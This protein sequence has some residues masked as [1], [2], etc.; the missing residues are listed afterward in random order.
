MVNASPNNGLN[1]SLIDNRQYWYFD[2]ST[3]WYR[4]MYVIF[5]SKYI[6]MIV[7]SY[8][9]RSKC[10]KIKANKTDILGLKSI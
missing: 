4:I 10:E 5:I 3:L 2:Q 9:F 6:I 8:T 1:G 7:N